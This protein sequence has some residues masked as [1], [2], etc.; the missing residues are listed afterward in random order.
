MAVTR[1][2]LYNIAT[3]FVGER[4]VDSLTENSEAR[5]LLDE[6]YTTGDGAVRYFMEQGNWNFAMRAI[7]IDSASDVEPV[8]GWSFAF[9]KPTDMVRLDQISADETFGTPLNDYE[10]EGSYIYA[11]VDPLYLRFVSDDDEWGGDLAKWPPSFALYAG[12]WLGLQIAPRL[13]SDLDQERIEK[14]VKKLCLEAAANDAVQ[15]PTRFPPLG[16]WARARFGGSRRD[17]GSRTR[18]TG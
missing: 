5:R 12:A 10:L 6:V 2:A 9:A 16:R 14:K 11:N 18:L 1:L 8:F 13:K 7:E 4:P 3:R 17:R 15:E